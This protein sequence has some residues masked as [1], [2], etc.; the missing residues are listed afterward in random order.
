MLD[1]MSFCGLFRSHYHIKVSHAQRER[2]KR[3]N[4]RPLILNHNYLFLHFYYISSSRR[5]ATFRT[6]L[7]DVPISELGYYMSI[8]SCCSFLSSSSLIWTPLSSL[9][10]H[11]NGYME[12]D[13]LQSFKYCLFI[14][15]SLYCEGH[16]G[17]SECVD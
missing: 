9:S 17:K 8:L 11:Y 10:V 4:T 15:A 2:K 7:I 3:I 16:H 13:I 6:T 5:E 12:S 1:K 14:H